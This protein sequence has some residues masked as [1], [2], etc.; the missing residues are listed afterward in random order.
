[1]SDAFDTYRGFTPSL[2]ASAT[3]A[4]AV[5][6]HDTNQLPYVTR[7]LYIG[8]AGDVKVTMAGQPGYPGADVVFPNVPVGIFS[9]RARRV[10]ATGTT[11]DDI[12]ALWSLL[13]A[14]LVWSTHGIVV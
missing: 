6:P 13:F 4:A 8:T 7:A 11:A 9:I 5:I 12:V 3:N 10:F 2:E 14:V 1:M